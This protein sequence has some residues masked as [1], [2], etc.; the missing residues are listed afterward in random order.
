MNAEEFDC[1]LLDKLKKKTKE[2][3]STVRRTRTF[4]LSDIKRSKKVK[5]VKKK[6]ESPKK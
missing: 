2:L 5:K 3:E 6:N 4:P 1:E